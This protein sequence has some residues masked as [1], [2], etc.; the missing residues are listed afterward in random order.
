[1]QSERIGVVEFAW[2]V[3]VLDIE[4]K[5]LDLILPGEEAIDVPIDAK[6]RQC[7]HGFPRG[8]RNRSECGGATASRCREGSCG[9]SA[10]NGTQQAVSG[11]RPDAIARPP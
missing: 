6:P 2:Y 10:R 7:P 4:V 5:F 1:M 11:R 9:L 3:Y 8:E